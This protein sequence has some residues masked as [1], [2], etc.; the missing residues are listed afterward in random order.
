MS[1]KS[2]LRANRAQPNR[3][4]IAQ[5]PLPGRSSNPYADLLYAALAALGY[6]RISFP[7]LTVPALWRG[8]RRVRFLHF[9]WLPETSYAPSLAPRT[10]KASAPRT[11]KAVLE[12][13]R[14]AFRLAFARLLGYR[15]VW[16]VHELRPPSANAVKGRIDRAG[17]AI[18][19]RS[20]QLLIAHD[21][22]MADRL[23]TYLGR[24]LAIEIIP[25]GT[26]KDIY[27]TGRPRAELRA[28]LAVAADAFVFLCFGQLR[29][30]KQV[31]LL[32]NAFASLRPADVRLVL[33]GVV[34][35]PRLRAEIE[36][37]AQADTRI[38]PMLGDVSPERVGEL[39]A[40]ADVFVLARGEIWTSGSLILALS[41]GLPAIAAR[42]P[43]AIELLGEDEEAGWLFT[44]GD[45]ESLA[46]A[47][48]RAAADRAEAARKRAAAHARGARLPTWED[49]A[50]RTAALFA[51]AEGERTLTRARSRSMPE[52]AETPDLREPCRTAPRT[53][54]SSAPR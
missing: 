7:A 13:C 25:H 52:Q 28:E 51:G 3:R 23:R 32:L 45:A 31:P 16:T 27:P 26:F 36:R 15:I 4:G 34:T 42:T 19:A 53:P 47:L 11:A 30:D 6:P 46:N 24:P 18:L 22:A 38:R 20:T 54:G 17:K 40:L 10:T 41:S 29:A 50:R 43:P 5:F 2:T 14:F 48:R 44:P 33:A 35:D 37:A 9:H 1:M 21:Q 12:L 8:R 49:V 39:L